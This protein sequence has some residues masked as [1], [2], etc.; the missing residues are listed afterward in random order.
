[1]IR[2]YSTTLND[3]QFATSVLQ[4]TERTSTTAKSGNMHKVEM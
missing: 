2:T 3:L 4:T 1:M